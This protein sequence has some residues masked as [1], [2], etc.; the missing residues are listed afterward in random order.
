MVWVL[1]P[2]SMSLRAQAI[3]VG[4]ADGNQ[5]VVLGGLSP[6]QEVVVAGTHVLVENQKVRRYGEAPG[7]KP[8]A[9]APAAAK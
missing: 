9:T 7:G 1:N 6:K 8:A 3:Q 4:G 2:S 5:V